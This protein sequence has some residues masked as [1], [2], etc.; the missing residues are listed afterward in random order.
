MTV[1]LAKRS[2]HV[3]PS[4]WLPRASASASAVGAEVAG[5]AADGDEDCV[6]AG[7]EPLEQVAHVAEG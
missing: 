4:P 5:V 7:P 2:E 1:T 6:A 3:P